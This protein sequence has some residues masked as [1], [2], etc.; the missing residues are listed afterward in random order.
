MYFA[1]FTIVTINL[2]NRQPTMIMHTPRSRHVQQPT[3]SHIPLYHGVKDIQRT[4]NVTIH[5]EFGGNFILPQ[6]WEYNVSNILI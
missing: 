2:V 5:G 4:E 1:P 6:I 3:K